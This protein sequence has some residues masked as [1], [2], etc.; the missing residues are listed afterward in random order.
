[1]NGA[2]VL[3]GAGRAKHGLIAAAVAVQ[4]HVTVPPA[5]M[6]STA[7]FADLLCPLLNTFRLSS[8]TARAYW[9]G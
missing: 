7:G 5:A 3:A 4:V 6:V 9:S 8:F 1:M 2:V